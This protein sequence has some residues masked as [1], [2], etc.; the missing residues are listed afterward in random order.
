MSVGGQ[1]DQDLQPAGFSFSVSSS[2]DEDNIL[3]DSELL[4]DGWPAEEE[5]EDAP[6]DMQLENGFLGADFHPRALDVNTLFSSQ[7]VAL[8]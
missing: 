3:D 5:P 7:Q 2:N 8:P 6:V 4:L 1:V